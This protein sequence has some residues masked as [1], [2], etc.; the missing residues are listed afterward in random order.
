MTPAA[1]PAPA[2]GG[3][4]TA[5]I[6]HMLPAATWDALAPSA[7]Y[8]AASLAQ[9][10]FIHC[11]AQPAWLLQ[12]ANRFYRGEPGP[13]L[14]LA[15]DTQALAA[16]VRWEAA[17]GHLFPHVYGP[18][19]RSAIVAVNSFPRGADGEF[20]LPPEFGGEQV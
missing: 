5:V 15:I 6:Y 9:E 2:S 17:D 11:T 1:E 3:M 18:L 14:I 10:G 12:V 8:A 4:P 16:P 7:A 13:W 20:R 19:N